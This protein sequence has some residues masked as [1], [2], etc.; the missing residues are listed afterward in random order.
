M[1][2]IYNVHCNKMQLLTLVSNIPEENC[3]PSAFFIGKL[4]LEMCGLLIEILCDWQNLR[5]TAFHCLL[6]L[7][8]GH[9]NSL[10]RCL[11][12]GFIEAQI[13]APSA[14]VAFTKWTFVH[15]AVFMALVSLSAQRCVICGI[16]FTN[17]QFFDEKS[18]NIHIF[19]LILLIERFKSSSK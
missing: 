6:L 12:I 8:W 3:K 11:V 18:C 1:P 19:R 4:E 9:I 17:L 2:H 16:F 15:T 7:S 10:G 14:A 5:A 13:C